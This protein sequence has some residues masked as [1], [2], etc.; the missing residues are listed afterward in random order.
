MKIGTIEDN[1]DY[2]VKEILTEL[3]ESLCEDGEE[4]NEDLIWDNKSELGELFF[5]AISDYMGMDE[6]IEDVE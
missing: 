6:A 2:Q 4:F 3:K 5:K 1:F